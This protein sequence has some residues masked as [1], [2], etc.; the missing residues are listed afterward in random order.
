MF[1]RI[2]PRYDLANHVLSL[3]VDR[4]WRLRLARRFRNV[5]ANPAARVL[6]LCCGTGDLAAAFGRVGPARAVG[7]D[8]AHPML[9]RAVVKDAA[10]GFVRSAVNGRGNRC[11]V[12]ADALDLPFSDMRFELAATAFGFR[13]LAN[14][15]RGLAEIRRVLKPGGTLAILEFCEPCGHLFGTLYRFYF[16]RLLPHIGGIISG[17]GAAYAYLPSSVTRFPSVVEL[18]RLIEAVGFRSARFEYWTGGIVALH[19][20]V[21]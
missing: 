15:E 21:R 16:H 6:D 5:L 18:V 19:T 1:S 11:Y 2:A 13:N 20:A 4:L 8:F 12:E 9:M 10:A 14:Y 3:E 7:I 17:D